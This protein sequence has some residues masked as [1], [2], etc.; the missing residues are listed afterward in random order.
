MREVGACFGAALRPLLS[1]V[2]HHATD[3]HRKTK[4]DLQITAHIKNYVK[5]HRRPLL[6]VHVQTGRGVHATGRSLGDCGEFQSSKHQTQPDCDPQQRR[7]LSN[8]LNI[9]A[10]KLC[11]LFI[12]WPRR[13]NEGGWL[14]QK[15]SVR[16]SGQ[17]PFCA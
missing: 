7:P 15:N 16:P 13:R 2:R 10:V 8:T 4:T 9:D 11:R 12:D 6:N 17:R 14:E 1:N 3:A 5:T